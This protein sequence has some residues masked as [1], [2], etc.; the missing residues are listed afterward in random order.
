M[1]KHQNAVLEFQ[2][3]RFVCFLALNSSLN[4]QCAQYRPCC[5]RGPIKQFKLTEHTSITGVATTRLDTLSASPRHAPDQ[6]AYRDL[7]DAVPLLPQGCCEGL[8]CR[9]VL[10]WVLTPR[11]TSLENVPQMLNRIQVT[12]GIALATS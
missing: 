11:N 4:T 8:Y 5:F 2:V 3:I 10:T 7:V 1:I 9:V 12:L 6:T